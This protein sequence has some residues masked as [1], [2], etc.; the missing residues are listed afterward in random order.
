M[1]I[2]KHGERLKYWLLK[3]APKSLYWKSDLS[4]AIN[5]EKTEA[6]ADLQELLQRCDD[7][8]ISEYFSAIKQKLKER[9]I[10][11]DLECEDSPVPKGWP[12][13]TD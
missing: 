1:V 9:A 4:G 6:L 7:E 11:A 8:E 2:L 12:E 3:N 5:Q 10:S 13:P